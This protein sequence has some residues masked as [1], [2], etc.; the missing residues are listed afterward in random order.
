MIRAYI[1]TNSKK[2][3]TKRVSDRKDNFVFNGG[4]YYIKPD[5]VFIDKTR[6]GNKQGLLY[7]E[8]YSLPLMMNDFAID[9]KLGSD[10]VF[11]DA[12]TVHEFTTAKSFKVLNSGEMELRDILLYVLVFVNIL[13]TA[14]IYGVLSSG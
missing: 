5:R 14:G 13:V 4:T 6:F 11:M 10:T 3:K 2:M 9:E 12:K 7:V 8:G 1:V